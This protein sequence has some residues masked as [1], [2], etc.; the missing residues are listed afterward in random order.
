MTLGFIEKTMMMMMMMMMMTFM[1]KTQSERLGAEMRC[2][3]DT[4]ALRHASNLEILRQP[5][6]P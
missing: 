4:K 6:E 3:L 5:Q 1:T 2:N